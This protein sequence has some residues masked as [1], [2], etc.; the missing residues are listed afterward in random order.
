MIAT[1]RRLAWVMNIVFRERS[2][3]SYMFCTAKAR[4][5]GKGAAHG[6]P[7][8]IGRWLVSYFDIAGCDGCGPL[9]RPWLIGVVPL[10][11]WLIPP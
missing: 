2:R 11:P 10:L 5:H 1:L 4:V 3:V 9:E 8:L 6:R 7:S